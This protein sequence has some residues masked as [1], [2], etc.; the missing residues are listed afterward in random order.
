MP[1]VPSIGPGVM[2]FTRTPIGPHSSA[3]HCTSMFTPALAAQTW[4]CSGAG[5]LAWP[6][7]MA[8]RLAPGF[9]C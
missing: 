4:A 6:A 7:V 1:S 2:A 3:R 9:R 5:F 8:I